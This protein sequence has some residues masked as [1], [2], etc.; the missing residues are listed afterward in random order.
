MCFSHIWIVAEFPLFRFYEF[1]YHNYFHFLN[2]IT[3]KYPIAVEYNNWHGKQ[4]PFWQ[5]FSYTQ[6]KSKYFWLHKIICQNSDSKWS[7][8]SKI[9][10]QTEAWYYQY[11]CFYK[12]LSRIT[13]SDLKILSYFNFSLSFGDF[14]LKY[15]VK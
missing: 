2:I 9:Y 6:K 4:Y 5:D 13:R 14:C 8:V 1:D 15:F 10:L 3:Y 11:I 7:E 12:I